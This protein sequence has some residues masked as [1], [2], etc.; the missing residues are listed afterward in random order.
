[1]TELLVL[2]A[3]QKKK[4]SGYDIQ[5][6]LQVSDA[7]TWGGVL[8]GS[9]YHSLN[10][11][12]KAGYIRVAAI[13]STGRRQKAIYETTG[14]GRSYYRELLQKVLS[15]NAVVYPT[16]FYAGLNF[17]SDLDSGEVR[18]ALKRQWQTIEEQ[19]ESL[20]AGM[21]EKKRCM[22]KDYQPVSDMVAENM[23]AHLQLQ[24]DFLVRLMELF[25]K[26]KECSGG[27]SEK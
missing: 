23:S 18:K 3:L 9:I 4:L 16:A 17:L 24:Q 27:E 12:E 10:K 8:V 2:G 5:V 21:E 11:L 7:E 25:E 20:R 22:G 14:E 1:M 15:D 6:M 13:E 26:Q 19:K